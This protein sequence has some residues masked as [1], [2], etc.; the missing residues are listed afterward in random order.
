MIL[1]RRLILVLSLLLVFTSAAYSAVAKKPVK[2]PVVKKVVKPAAKPSTSF[3]PA[4]PM[5]GQWA[6]MNKP[7]YLGEGIELLVFTLKSAEFTA[8][9]VYFSDT[10][11][12]PGKSE[13]MLV[14][15]FSIQ[16]P[17]KSE[18]IINWATCRFTAVDSSDNNRESVGHIGQDKNKEKLD[19][20]LKP[21]QKVD[22]YTCIKLPGDCLAPKLIVRPSE[23]L[24]VLR[25]DLHGKVK[26]LEPMFADPNDKTGATA[27]SDVKANKGQLCP[28]MM[29][30]FTYDNIKFVSGPY[31]DRE[32]EEGYG[33][34][35]IEATIKNQSKDQQFINWATITPSLKGKSGTIDFSTFASAEGTGSFDTTLDP[36]ESVGVQY[37]FQ[38]RNNAEL[39]TFMLEEGEDARRYVWDLGAVIASFDVPDAPTEDE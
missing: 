37:C 20:S 4:K 34:A 8:S 23:D 19:M 25:Y 10:I 2:K 39:R 31:A 5:P 27:V 36:G 9:R 32:P 35:V 29:F 24:A 18:Y 12:N 11:V 16:N 22:C 14:L 6:E 15:H 3:Q 28:G 26:A 33:W 1:N 13:K 21:A 38:V 17:T 7:Y 30:D